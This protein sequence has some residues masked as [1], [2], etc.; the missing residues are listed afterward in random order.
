[1]MYHFPL[2]IHI[3]MESLQNREP[4]VPQKKKTFIDVL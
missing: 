4:F 1:M 3:Q 2:S